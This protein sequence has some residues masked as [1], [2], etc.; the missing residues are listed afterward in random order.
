LQSA[1]KAIK[2]CRNLTNRSLRALAHFHVD[3]GAGVNLFTN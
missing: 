3:A 2:T 1:S